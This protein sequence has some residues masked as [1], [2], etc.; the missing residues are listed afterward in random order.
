MKQIAFIN[1][2]QSRQIQQ[3]TNLLL[4]F[5]LYFPVNKVW[6]IM[7]IVSLGDNCYEVSNPV[8]WKNKKNI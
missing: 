3:T 6:Q 2:K 1:F 5:F 4:Y 7:H 8:S